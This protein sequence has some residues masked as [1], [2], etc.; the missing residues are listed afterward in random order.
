[1]P[2]DLSNLTQALR[3]GVQKAHNYEVHIYTPI[4]DPFMRELH[5]MCHTTSLPGK[6]FITK[7]FTTY[8]VP[9]KLPSHIN[10]S[11][12]ITLEFYCTG[13]MRERLFFDTWQSYIA[14][15]TNFYFQY[16]DQYKANIDITT[17]TEDGKANYV[18]RLEDAYPIS[19]LEQP[20]KANDQGILNLAVRFAFWRWR[21]MDDIAKE[22]SAQNAVVELQDRVYQPPT[23]DTKD[24]WYPGPAPKSPN[25]ITDQQRAAEAA[26]NGNSNRVSQAIHDMGWENA[27]KQPPSE[28]TLGNKQPIPV[29]PDIQLPTTNV[30]IRV[31]TP[32]T[33]LPTE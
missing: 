3:Y 10:F 18:I 31:P 32:G 30:P 14:N 25:D 17:F 26:S 7:P 13:W 8:G 21:N 24:S 33:T 5:T 29:D 12:G 9:R 23:P 19:V 11:E 1:M 16:F 2:F 27:T 6:D 15:P 4:P 28:P 20:L 22:G